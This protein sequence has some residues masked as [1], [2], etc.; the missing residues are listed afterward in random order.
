M[1]ENGKAKV[2]FDFRFLVDEFGITKLK[3]GYLD[4]TSFL[5]YNTRKKIQQG[6]YDQSQHY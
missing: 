4:K 5:I 2:D 1:F 6:I 3:Q